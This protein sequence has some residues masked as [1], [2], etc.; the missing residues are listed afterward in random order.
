MLPLFC[1]IDMLDST[2]SV[3][4]SHTSWYISEER[5]PLCTGC[6]HCVMHNDVIQNPYTVGDIFGKVPE[7]QLWL[8]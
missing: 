4:V 7:I 1:C 6:K 8:F 5:S 3:P 2:A